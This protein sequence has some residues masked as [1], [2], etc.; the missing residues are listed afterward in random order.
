MIALLGTVV[1]ATSACTP[2]GGSGTPFTITGTVQ[3]L[4]PGVQG[5]LLLTAHNPNSVPISVTSL[6]VATSSA[7]AAC[8]ASN[9]TTTDFTGTLDVPANSTATQSVP[10]SLAAVAP[11][12][13][14]NVSFSL[15]YTGAATYLQRFVTHTTLT[16]SNNP[17][18]VDEPV[19]FTADVSIDPPAPPSPP[20]G[21]V[22]FSDG[23]EVLGTVNVGRDSKASL[24]TS[25]LTVGSHD[26]KAVYNGE[27]NF[28][29][30]TSSIVTQQVHAHTK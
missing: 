13:C 4:M 9:L 19:T 27:P 12:G 17:S 8:P 21:S 28:T 6:Q 10:I 5:S 22:T 7:P 2:T 24:V 20:S 3:D 23:S 26:I 16:S 11:D 14:Q 15:T 30:S 29:A 1:I 18:T 25:R